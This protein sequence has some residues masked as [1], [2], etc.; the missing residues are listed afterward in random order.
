MSPRVD[1]TNG[2]FIGAVH[3]GDLVDSLQLIHGALRDEQGSLLDSG[4]GSHPTVLA[5][6]QDVSGIGEESGH[7]DGAGPDVHL[8]IRKIEL[9][10]VRIGGAIGEN[11][12]EF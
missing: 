1:G 3:N 9:P 12:L 8:A 5:G 4:C 10:L 7:P 6:T 11:Q 2:H